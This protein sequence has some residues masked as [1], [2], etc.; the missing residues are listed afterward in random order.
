MISFPNTMTTP[1]SS[2]NDS[3]DF[4]V[5]EDGTIRDMQNDSGSFFAS[6]RTRSGRKVTTNRKAFLWT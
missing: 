3:D 6:R 5:E 1:E 2:D 4:A